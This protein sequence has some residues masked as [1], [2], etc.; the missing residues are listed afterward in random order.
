LYFSERFDNSCKHIIVR[1]LALV[2]LAN[3]RQ[4]ANVCPD[5]RATAGGSG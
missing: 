4:T 2:K 5:G 1:E 3:S